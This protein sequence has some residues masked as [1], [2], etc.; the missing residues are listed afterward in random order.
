M[1]ASLQVYPIYTNFG[2]NC[3]FVSGGWIT[4]YAVTWMV[5]SQINQEFNPAVYKMTR[6]S[7]LWC[8]MSH[9]FWALAFLTCFVVPF[10][11]HFPFAIA[12]ILCLLFTE[13]MCLLSYILFTKLHSKLMGNAHNQTGVAA[14]A[15]TS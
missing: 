9:S 7:A 3:K 15:S 4:L 10:K 8:Y 1:I 13:A 11:H 5:R 2:L 12:I 6:E 14:A